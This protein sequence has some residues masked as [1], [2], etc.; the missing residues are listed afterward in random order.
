[1]QSEIHFHERLRK[2][3]IDFSK[4]WKRKTDIG[5][6]TISCS[7]RRR[8]LLTTSWSFVIWICIYYHISHIEA[9]QG[10]KFYYIYMPPP[11]QSETHGFTLCNNRRALAIAQQFNLSHVY[12]VPHFF[13]CWPD[14]IVSN[15]WLN[16]PLIFVIDFRKSFSSFSSSGNSSLSSKQ[17]II[18]GD[19]SAYFLAIRFPDFKNAPMVLFFLFYF[20]YSFLYFIAVLCCWTDFK[21]EWDLLYSLSHTHPGYTKFLYATKHLIAFAVYYCTFDVTLDCVVQVIVFF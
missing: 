17:H 16:G 6:L 5:E 12:I 21:S 10:R 9:R 8:S 19:E 18:K 1:M 4:C 14:M 11:L 13:A 15:W 2:R 20:F 3:M 7:R